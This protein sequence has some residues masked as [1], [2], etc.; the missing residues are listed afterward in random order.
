MP[1]NIKL[2]N[3]SSPELVTP[4]KLAGNARDVHG[5]EGGSKRAQKIVKRRLRKTFHHELPVQGALLSADVAKLPDGSMWFVAGCQDATVHIWK[6]SPGNM[7]GRLQIAVTYPPPLPT[8][9]QDSTPSTACP[10]QSCVS[11]L[12]D[13]ICLVNLTSLPFQSLGA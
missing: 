2:A 6:V 10:G 11:S 12:M 4:M 5:R 13:P 1:S 9:C 8:T 7:P 3:E